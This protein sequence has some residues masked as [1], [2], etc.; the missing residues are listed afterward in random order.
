MNKQ[1]AAL[2]LEQ[3]QTRLEQARQRCETAKQHH[4]ARKSR[5]L[6]LTE[7]LKVVGLLHLLGALRDNPSTLETFRSFNA[8]EAKGEELTYP[9]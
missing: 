6:A 2:A 4:I 8:M 9:Y 1:N 5:N 3:A 7:M